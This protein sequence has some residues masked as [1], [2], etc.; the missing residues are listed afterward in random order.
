MPAFFIFILTV[1]LL[2]FRSGELVIESQRTR[3]LALNMADCID[4]LRSAIFRCES[5]INEGKYK[6]DLELPNIRLDAARKA[7]QKLYEF[8]NSQSY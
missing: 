2:F 1:T 4:K 8:D 3:S 5:D 7:R 6:K